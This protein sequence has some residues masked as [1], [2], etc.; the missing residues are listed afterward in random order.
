MAIEAATPIE[1]IGADCIAGSATRATVIPDAANAAPTMP[2]IILFKNFLQSRSA[3]CPGSDSAR[4]DSIPSLSLD[5]SI[6]RTYE[7]TN[8]YKCTNRKERRTFSRIG[9]FPVSSSRPKGS[10]LGKAGIQ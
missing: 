9:V 7:C 5:M 6:W 1:I 3:V 2:R 10:P 8:G 4:Q